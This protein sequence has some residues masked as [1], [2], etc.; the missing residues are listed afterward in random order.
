MHQ[1]MKNAIMVLSKHHEMPA[2]V[3]PHPSLVV[4]CEVLAIMER[5]RKCFLLF[6]RV[7]PA[8]DGSGH[9]VDARW[10]GYFGLGT[11]RP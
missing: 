10:H 4:S 11:L 3:L 5:E 2:E 6:A 7:S 1:A 9:R 8:A